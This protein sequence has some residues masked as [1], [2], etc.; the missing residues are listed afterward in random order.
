MKQGVFDVDAENG[1]TLI[2]L[3]QD[4]SIEDVITSTGCE[5]QVSPE[6]KTME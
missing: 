3:G 2:E 1:L 5:F 6:L 4:I